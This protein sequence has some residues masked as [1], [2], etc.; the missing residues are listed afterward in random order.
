MINTL[1]HLDRKR[2]EALCQQQEV[3]RLAVFG[4]A[5]RSDFEPASDIDILVEFQPGARVG[6]AFFML[7]DELSALFGRRVDLNTPAF[8]GRDIRD[9]VLAEA[10]TLYVAA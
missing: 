10:E 8:L 4:S 3:Q 2:L 6:F 9:T 5:L 1:A 7:Q